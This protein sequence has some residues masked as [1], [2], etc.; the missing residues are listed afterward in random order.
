MLGM[1]CQQAGAPTCSRL[2]GHDDA[3]SRL[4]S[5]A[6]VTDGR[7]GSPSRPRVFLA[8]EVASARRP[9]LSHPAVTDALHWKSALRTRKCQMFG[10]PQAVKKKPGEG[11]G[12]TKY[13]CSA[14]GD[15]GRGASRNGP[16]PF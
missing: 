13:E 10:K 16:Q 4:E 7:D 11:T 5:N 3:E 8:G 2:H 15:L 1:K 6:S 14:D 9:Y 12:L